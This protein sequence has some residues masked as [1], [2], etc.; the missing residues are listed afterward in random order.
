MD[1]L[2][3]NPRKIWL[4]FLKAI[5]ATTLSERYALQSETHQ[6]DVMARPLR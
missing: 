3:V 5:H 1:R 2:L 4:I 6:R